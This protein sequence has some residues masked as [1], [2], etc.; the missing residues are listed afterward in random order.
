MSVT[1]ASV[2]EQ[3]FVQPKKKLSAKMSSTVINTNWQE[4]FYWRKRDRGMLESER[5]SWSE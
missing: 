4:E 3:L 1:G 5:S 2:L